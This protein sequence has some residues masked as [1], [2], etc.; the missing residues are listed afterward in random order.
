MGRRDAAAPRPTGSLTLLAFILLTVLGVL[1]MHG[2]AMPAASPHSL[3][4]VSATSLS[5]AQGTTMTFADHPHGAR[6]HFLSPCV[7]DAARSALVVK[8]TAPEIS[9]T[10]ADR[11][12]V[13]VQARRLEAR[14]LPPPD[15]Q[16]LCISR[17]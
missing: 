3:H 9:T 15:L 8:T 1:A 4:A 12:P 16:E 17:P 6:H 2:A 11:D 5:S 13:S 7:A 10:T 14:A